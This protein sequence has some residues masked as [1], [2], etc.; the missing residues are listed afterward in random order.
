VAI[1]LDE[2]TALLRQGPDIRQAE[3]QLAATIAEI[4]VAMADLFPRICLSRAI[5]RQSRGSWFSPLRHA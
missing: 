5:G 3:R 2:L 1:S 4:G